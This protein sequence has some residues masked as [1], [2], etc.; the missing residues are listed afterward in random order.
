MRPDESHKL[1]DYAEHYAALAA[2]TRLVAGVDAAIGSYE[3]AYQHAAM[4]VSSEYKFYGYERIVD[5][6]LEGDDEAGAIAAIQRVL[7]SR[8]G[9]KCWKSISDHA[10]AKRNGDSARQAARK[11][12]ALLDQDGFEPFMA[13]DIAHVAASVARSGENELAR[14]LFVRAID[15]SKNN[16][17]P[18]FNHPWIAKLQVHGDLLFD[19]Y[20][21]IQAIEEAEDRVQPLAELALAAAISEFKA[22]N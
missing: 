8:S 3:A 16:H 13:H 15:L 4:V 5:T 14:R 20:Q 17:P 6:L 18:K 12:T 21:T 9:A 22:T 2:R 11:A 1:I 7:D 10:R 19:A